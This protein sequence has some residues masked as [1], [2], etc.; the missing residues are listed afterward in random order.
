V[1]SGKNNEFSI[2]LGLVVGLLLA[3]GLIYLFMFT[4]AKDGF[5]KNMARINAADGEQIAIRI[6]PVVTIKDILGE[7]SDAETKTETVAVKSP[8]ELYSGACLACHD[9]GVAGAPKPGDR[10][11]WE[12]RFANGID[13][14][15]DTAVNGKGAMPPNGAS[16][17]SREELRS[18]IEFML[19]RAGL[20]EM[21]VPA[22][23]EPEPAAPVAAV[24]APVAQDLNDGDI[25]GSEDILPP[26]AAAAPAAL[27][28]AAAGEGTYR[29]ACFACHDSGAAGAPRLGEAAAWS[30]RIASGSDTMLNSAINGKGAM[31]PKGGHGYLSD[32]EIANAVAFML[33]RVQ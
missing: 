29:R 18:A 31:P 25:A 12:P 8:E 28:D 10:A 17:Y 7:Q 27:G 20:M 14:L 16:S 22:A 33:S 3:V 1:A 5:G 2:S 23:A 21:S 4:M 32:S 13:A 30:A 6:K 26:T 19:A 24:E 11:A 15:L 9:T